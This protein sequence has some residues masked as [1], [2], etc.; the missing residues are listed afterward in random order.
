MDGA[1]SHSETLISIPEG[2]DIK[3]NNRHLWI[4]GASVKGRRHEQ[5][6]Q[7]CQDAFAIA[8]EGERWG[9]AVA[10][11]VGSASHAETG[12]FIAVNKAVQSL[13]YRE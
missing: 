9:I 1:L 3:K 11:G 7:P 6:G 12:A 10:D 5:S 4:T 2:S 8:G 13:L